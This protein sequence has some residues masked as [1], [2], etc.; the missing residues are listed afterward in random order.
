MGIGTAVANRVASHLGAIANEVMAAQ[1]KAFGALEI[2]KTGD[3]YTMT[4]AA[5]DEGAKNP[6]RVPEISSP[7]SSSIGAHVDTKASTEAA[8]IIFRFG[9]WPAALA[10]RG[11]APTDPRANHW[12][13]SNWQG[14]ARIRSANS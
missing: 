10:L 1:V 12:V 14:D 13:E 6:R 9:L 4:Q 3:P 5:Q 11:I 2:Y 7:T 8:R